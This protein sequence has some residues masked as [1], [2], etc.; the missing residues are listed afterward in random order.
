MLYL[1]GPCGGGIRGRMEGNLLKKER[2]LNG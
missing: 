2:K 1:N